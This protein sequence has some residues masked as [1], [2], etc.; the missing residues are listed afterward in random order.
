MEHRI[1]P[2]GSARREAPPIVEHLER[3]TLTPEVFEI[4][5]FQTGHKTHGLKRDGE[6]TTSN[7]MPL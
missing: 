4:E 6:S 5:Q 1:R 7:L 3:L 2:A